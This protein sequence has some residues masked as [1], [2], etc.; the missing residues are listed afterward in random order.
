MST[1][2]QLDQ[3]PDRPR[4][5]VVGAGGIGGYYGGLLAHAGHDVT[6]F[7]R[8][9]HYRAIQEH[10]L[11]VKSVVG[12]FLVHA[13][14]VCSNA[15]DVESPD[16]VLFCV[17]TYDTAEVAS[18]LREAFGKTALVVSVQNGVDNHRK[19]A[20]CVDTPNVFPGLAQIVSARVAPGVIKQS[21]GPR[22]LIFGDPSHEANA[23]LESL[24]ALMRDS[25]IDA[26]ASTDI[27][28]DVWRKFVFIVAFSGLTVL[29]RCP[30]GRILKDPSS[31]DLVARALTEAIEVAH[32]VGV[33]M[34]PGS[35]DEALGRI[36]AYRG[37][38]EGATSSLLRDLEAGNR[39]EIDSLNGEISRL[40]AE[41]G[42]DVP[43]HKTIDVAVRLATN[44]QYVG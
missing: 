37:P 19:I 17:K 42:V 31:M 21:G 9:D 40:G 34:P 26:K 41:H 32:A 24:A 2:G 30:I 44:D 6:L 27:Q 5:L 16:L 36:N 14:K 1:D 39:T 3:M 15:E 33:E 38:Q 28:L 22:T 7:C 20:A 13:V 18:T 11:Q 25:D 43:I 12:E 29:G 35:L 10:G 8:G 23:L 4:I